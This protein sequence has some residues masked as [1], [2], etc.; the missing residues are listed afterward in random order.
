VAGAGGG[1]WHLMVNGYYW[2]RLRLISD[3]WFFDESKYNVGH[4]VDH[5]AATVTAWYG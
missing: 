3:R 2:G 5:F 1:V 4:L